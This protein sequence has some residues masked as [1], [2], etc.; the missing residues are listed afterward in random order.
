MHINKKVFSWIN[1]FIK[2]Y[3]SHYCKLY[4]INYILMM[5]EEDWIVD[6]KF[7]KSIL[8]KETLLL[9]NQTT[10]LQEYTNHLKSP[11][12]STNVSLDFLEKNYHLETK[13]GI[14]NF[15]EKHS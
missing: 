12:E 2:V 8:N 4:I 3:T 6:G 15:L 9:I 5:Y 7:S 11:Y 13:G 14:Y 10:I 1:K